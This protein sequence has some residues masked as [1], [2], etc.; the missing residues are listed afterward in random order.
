MSTY[1]SNSPTYLPTIQPFQPDFQMYAGT[2]EMKQTKF[3]SNEKQL[4]TLYGSLLNSPMLREQNI[5]TRDEFFKTVEYEIKKIE[6]LDLSLEENVNQSAQ[7]FTALYDDK[8]IVKDM[9][10]TKNYYN[11]KERGE[12]FRNCFDPEKCGGEFWQG[13]VDALDYRAEEFRMLSDQEAMN[14]GD[15]RYT[16]YVNVMKEAQKI[17][18]DMGF[19]PI[20][21]D[22]ILGNGYILKTTNGPELASGPIMSIFSETFKNDPQLQDYY[23][24]SAYLERKNW[25]R[26]NA[27]QYGSVELAEQVYIEQKRKAINDMFAPVKEETDFANEVEGNNRKSIEDKI[28]TQGTNGNDDLAAAYMATLEK[29]QQL[30]ATSQL[31]GQALESSEKSK[32]ASKISYAGEAID[33]A[34]GSAL[35]NVDVQKA[36]IATS[37]SGYKQELRVDEGY[38]NE[39]KMANDRLV[40][41]MA[42]KA[43]QEEEKTQED[44]W[45]F[46]FEV[47]SPSE[48]GGGSEINLADDSAA[49]LVE[50][51]TTK[52]K[53]EFQGINTKINTSL[54]EATK[55]DATTGYDTNGQ[56][57]SDL[58]TQ[59]D[60]LFNEFSNWADKKGSVAE[61][62]DAA[63]KMS[64]WNKKSPKEK[65]AWAKKGGYEYIFNKLDE[66]SQYNMYQKAYKPL[67]TS[68]PNNKVNRQHLQPIIQNLY[69][70]FQQA[71]NAMVVK[72]SW[73]DI[74]K[75]LFTGAI[76]SLNATGDDSPLSQFYSYAVGDKG[77]RNANQ[78]AVAYAMDKTNAK[79]KIDR[80]KKSATGLP[81]WMEQTMAPPTKRKVV[82][83]E[84]MGKDMKVRKEKRYADNNQV[85]VPTAGDMAKGF[86]DATFKMFDDVAPKINIKDGS[87]K[88]KKVWATEFFT[89]DYDVAPQYEQYV[90]KWEFDKEGRGATF[91]K[92]FRDAKWA[93]VMGDKKDAW[94]K[95]SDGTWV[96]APY[97]ERT[98]MLGRGLSNLFT[99]GPGAMWEGAFG[100][101]LASGQEFRK[102]ETNDYFNKFTNYNTDYEDYFGAG[103]EGKS[104]VIIED[105]NRQI[106]NITI[107]GGR[108]FSELVDMGSFSAKTLKG[109]FSTDA[110]NGG[111]NNKQNVGF[112]QYIN[113]SKTTGIGTD[114]GSSIVA[115]GNNQEKLPGHNDIANNLLQQLLTLSTQKATKDKGKISLQYTYSNVGGSKEDMQAMTIKPVF[116]NMP[117]S[118]LKTM[119]SDLTGEAPDSEIVKNYLKTI[120]N[121]G[122]TLYQPDAVAE[123]YRPGSKKEQQF[124]D[125]G[126]HYLYNTTKRQALEKV[127][128]ITKE[129][130]VPGYDDITDLRI[131]KEGGQY[132]VKGSYQTGY[133][134][135]NKRK[136]MDP[137]P[138]ITFD[139]NMPLHEILYQMPIQTREGSYAGLN[140]FLAAQRQTLISMNAY[141]GSEKVFD[142]SYVPELWLQKFGNIVQPTPPSKNA[143][144]SKSNFYREPLSGDTFDREGRLV[145]MA[146]P[147][148]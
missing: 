88:P 14:F 43:K 51:E 118:F 85:V 83:Y 107:P 3:D 146:G 126:G 70:E 1:L 112:W 24:T 40:A 134:F 48:S 50:K 104:P 113:A 110:A 25:T 15:I 10:W 4:S 145:R 62:R 111:F 76:N 123:S 44:F 99:G 135:N 75:G 140:G 36:A 59:V 124:G 106:G 98:T 38:W 129:I 6:N 81:A 136:V 68:S 47:G 7:L 84:V 130:Q 132:K 45:S 143:T 89:D 80:T 90:D 78:F 79:W 133:D 73:E 114:D 27:E 144:F 64:S 8:N 13:G 11:Q 23:Q 137:I 58:V 67:A 35:F 116:E 33:G 117:E 93:W 86:S 52:A 16:P 26:A 95:T 131:V 69:P 72:N 42:A 96:P 63:G 138:E 128:D 31:L 61:Q 100:G 122:I 120:T 5:K 60:V 102:E 12:N 39:R 29:E 57:S 87:G 142:P 97:Q 41:S 105:I 34:W 65:L 22:Q 121:E 32:N 37:Y 108:T 94:K 30:G 139:S 19:D 148:Y 54:F 71:S 49:N 53:Q 115:F 17:M 127:M 9:M 56:S 2:L 28:R 21:Q 55:L 91:E 147:K 103:Y 82:E 18:K 46:D 74:Q 20:E 101:E 66:S 109:L 77:A 119:L 92:N 125:L 141:E